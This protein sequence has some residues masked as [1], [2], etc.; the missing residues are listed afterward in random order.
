MLI[1]EFEYIVVYSS[2]FSSL[3]IVWNFLLMSSWVPAWLI[4]HHKLLVVKLS[5]KLPSIPKPLGKY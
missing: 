3:T 2:I 1:F 4:L 5:A